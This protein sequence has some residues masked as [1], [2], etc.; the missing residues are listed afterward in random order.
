MT[1]LHFVQ[2]GDTISSIADQYNIS[3]TRLESDNDLS[4]NQSLVEGQLL[5]IAY[6]E[7][8]Y[9]IIK[10]DTL[11]SIATKFG[12]PLIQLLRN[13]PHLSEMSFQAELVEG[14]EITI[15]Y[16][17]RERKL[18]VNGFANAFINQSV[19]R[20]TLPYLTYIYYCIKLPS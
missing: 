13:N 4:P 3:I 16:N 15:S 10:G 5:I 18:R 6:P 17:N 12:I 1:K 9:S 14:D 11:S 8:T 19:L 20:R 2:K 7:R